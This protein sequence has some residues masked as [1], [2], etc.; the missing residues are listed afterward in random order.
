MTEAFP[1]GAV[2]TAGPDLEA[3]VRTDPGLMDLW[4][5]LTPLGRNE[6]LCWVEDA[7]QAATRERRI[8][9]QT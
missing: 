6:F 1:Q 9:R 5:G 8:V 7:K 3:A 4:A 2:H